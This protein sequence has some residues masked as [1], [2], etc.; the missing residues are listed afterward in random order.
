MCQLNK[1]ILALV[2]LLL[3]SL[4]LTCY[5]WN[6]SGTKDITIESYAIA[7]TSSKAEKN[8]ANLMLHSAL[9]AHIENNNIEKAEQ[10]LLGL[11]HSEL[12]I[13]KKN[14]ED[15]NLKP[16]TRERLIEWLKLVEQQ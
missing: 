15:P 1:Y 3:A 2:I 12:I 4:T 9:L 14:I 11:I 16:E 7:D 10:L 13:I 8:A 5:F 6:Q